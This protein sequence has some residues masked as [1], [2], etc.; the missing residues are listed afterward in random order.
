MIEDP[1]VAAEVAALEANVGL[2]PAEACRQALA[3]IRRHY[4]V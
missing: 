3:A 2:A 4:A 1:E